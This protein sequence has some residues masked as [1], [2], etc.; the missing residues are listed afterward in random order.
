MC[1]LCVF[2]PLKALTANKL[3][4]WSWDAVNYILAGLDLADTSVNSAAPEP[5]VN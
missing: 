4:V 3:G 2:I 1:L 5:M